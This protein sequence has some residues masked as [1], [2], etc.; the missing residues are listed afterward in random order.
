MLFLSPI[1]VCLLNILP[2]EVK[3]PKAPSLAPF[4]FCFSMAQWYQIHWNHCGTFI[5]RFLAFPP[6]YL[7]LLRNYITESKDECWQNKEYLLNTSIMSTSGEQRYYVYV[8]VVFI[9]NIKSSSMWAR[10]KKVIFKTVVQP[11]API[12]VIKL[13]IWQVDCKPTFTHMQYATATF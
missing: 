13:P 4:R 12:L 2:T 7:V 5:A 8:V 1:V 3:M 9:T 11:V 10:V 6:D